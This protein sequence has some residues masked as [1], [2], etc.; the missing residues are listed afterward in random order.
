MTILEIELLDMGARLY[1]RQVMAKAE[2]AAE[3]A[4]LKRQDR[5]EA[6]WREVDQRETGAALLVWPTKG[7]RW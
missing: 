5:A 2:L 1:A 3:L 6:F 7:A 4:E